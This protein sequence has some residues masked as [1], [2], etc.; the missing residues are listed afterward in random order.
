MVKIDSIEKINIFN[1][2]ITLKN[3]DDFIAVDTEF[4]REEISS[5]LL[6]LIQIATESTV[7]IIDPFSV[8][9]DFLKPHFENQKLK[10]VF[11][12]AQQDIEILSLAGITTNNIYDTQLYEML[13]NTRENISYQSIVFNYLKKKL[14]KSHTQSNW[15]QRPLTNQQFKYA[16]DDVF[17]LRKVFE[18]QQKCLKDL[19][20]ENWLDN[21]TNQN[22]KEKPIRKFIDKENLPILDTLLDWRKNKATE[23]NIPEQNVVKDELILSIL[24]KGTEFVHSLHNSRNITDETT[25]EFINFSL[26]VS[27]NI[28]IKDKPEHITEIKLLKTLLSIKSE[29]LKISPMMISTTKDLVSFLNGENDIKFLTGWRY[30][31]FGYFANKL[32]NG[33]IKLGIKNKKTIII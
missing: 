21:E 16:A 18:K 1:E 26:T 13:L 24:K 14:P 32:L 27:D 9:I 3:S 29:E 31:V 4:I 20:R 12:S 25:K 17:Y 33:E 22:P 2:D 6:C 11:H 30:D 8:S 10:K 15:G 19:N 23:L 28:V 5:P 7:Y